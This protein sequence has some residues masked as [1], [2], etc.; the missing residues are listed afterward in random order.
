MRR[1]ITDVQ[2]RVL[3]AL[4]VTGTPEEGE[5]LYIGYNTHVDGDLSLGGELRL[6]VYGPYMTD[7]IIN[8]GGSESSTAPDQVFESIQADWYRLP[9]NESN[10]LQW[11]V[12]QD[13]STL[14][15]RG[16]RWTQD[17]EPVVLRL[18]Y[19]DGNITESTSTSE[20]FMIFSGEK[21]VGGFVNTTYA[22]SVYLFRGEIWFA[23]ATNQ[24]QNLKVN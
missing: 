2:Q 20:P 23:F 5:E 24:V 14:T 6:Y 13:L 16:L 4:E 19:L 22:V 10:N 17:R 3:N 7:Y 15:L 1:M 12:L 21:H 11:D 9:Q 8:K 18:S